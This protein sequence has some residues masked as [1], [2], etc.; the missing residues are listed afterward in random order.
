MPLG[1]KRIRSSTRVTLLSAAGAGLLVAVHALVIY[2]RFLAHIV[3]DVEHEAVRDGAHIGHMIAE[4]EPFARGITPALRESV[5]Q[6]ASEFGLWKLRL[7]DRDG[8]IV[9]STLSGEEG[10]LNR[11]AYFREQVAAGRV[12]SKAVWKERRTLEHVASGRDVVE[13]YVPMMIGGTFRGALEIYSDVTERKARLDSLHRESLLATVGIVLALLAVIVLLARKAER[14]ALERERL[15]EQLIRSDRLAAMGTLVGGMAHEFNNINVS[16]MGF[17]ELAL[18]G[19]GLSGETREFL[20]RIF[21]AARRA[22]AITNNLLDFSQ[23][24]SITREPVALDA[25]LREALE[26]VRAQFEK[27]GIVFD[28]LLEPLPPSSMDRD[29]IVQVFLNLLTNARHAL[30][31][32]PTRRITLETGLDKGRAMAR[33]VDAGCGIPADRLSQIFTPFYSTKGEHAGGGALARVRGTGLGLSVSHTIVRQHD[34]EI[35]VESTPGSG[36]SVTVRLPLAG[37][38]GSAA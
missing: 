30:L 16:V 38:G 15:Q 21:R 7:F 37:E 25:A 14:D 26:L 1:L 8:R 22:R 12:V 35:L 13:V 4:H 11:H 5:A 2:P 6:I 29:L 3:H 23:L 9:L 24:R 36:T 20:D 31:E 17:S 18:R 10:Q 19:E 34:G 32:A 33:V 28:L 27:E